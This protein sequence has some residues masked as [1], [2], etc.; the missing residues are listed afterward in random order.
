M[1]KKQITIA[2]SAMMLAGAS[3]T[4]I[5][6][7]VEANPNAYWGG[8]CP[9]YT[10]TS[11]AGY[12]WL[13]SHPSMRART[14]SHARN[15]EVLMSVTNHWGAPISSGS[16]VL[17]RRWN[18]YRYWA[19]R[20]VMGCSN[21]IGAETNMTYSYSP[22]VSTNEQAPQSQSTPSNSSTTSTSNE[23][24]EKPDPDFLY[25]LKDF[26]TVGGCVS[27]KK[28]AGLLTLKTEF[29]GVIVAINGETATVRIEKAEPKYDE[30]K[31]YTFLKSEIF[32]FQC[33]HYHNQGTAYWIK[34][35]LGV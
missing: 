34:K 4:G 13:K 11:Y 26:W 27:S 21:T 6:S 35:K 23:P 3:L 16:W 31:N 18:G 9:Q 1:L 19:H 33:H 17:V 10:V 24:L 2:F 22:P 7:P 30:K 32:G 20:S 25:G 28:T 8:N 5:A 15:G 14:I 12:A 29:T